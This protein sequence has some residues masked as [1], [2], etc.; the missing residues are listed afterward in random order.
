VFN[1]DTGVG[2]LQINNIETCIRG[3][4]VGPFSRG[5]FSRVDKGIDWLDF[6]AGSH[7]RKPE[8]VRTETTRH[9]SGRT[10]TGRHLYLVAQ[11]DSN[12][13]SQIS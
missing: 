9:L 4:R 5:N 12:D 11:C 10:D 1:S 3:L 6:I 8:K 7:S 2:V 13:V